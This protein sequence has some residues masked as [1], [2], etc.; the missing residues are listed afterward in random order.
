MI[1]IFSDQLVV[2][3]FYFGSMENWGLVVYAETSILYNPDYSSIDHQRFIAYATAHEISHM[4]SPS[5]LLIIVIS[6][7]TV[8][9]D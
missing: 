2:P 6:Y 8:R 7:P 4:V 1:N 5:L 3:V 9:F